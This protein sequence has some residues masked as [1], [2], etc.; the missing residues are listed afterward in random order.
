MSKSS[1]N[2][3]VSAP[4][5]CKFKYW[6]TGMAKV[7]ALYDN[8]FEQQ[9]KTCRTGQ[10]VANL[11]SKLK[12]APILVKMQNME[13]GYR[14]QRLFRMRT[15]HQRECVTGITVS[16][17]LTGPGMRE[18]SAQGTFFAN[19]TEVSAYLPGGKIVH[20]SKEHISEYEKN[21]FAR[22]VKQFPMSVAGNL[23]I[24]Y[25]LFLAG[26]SPLKGGNN[27]QP[28]WRN[29]LDEV[30]VLQTPMT[31]RL[32]PGLLANL[33]AFFAM[34][35]EVYGGAALPGG[36]LA[37]RY[38]SIRHLAEGRSTY[39]AGDLFTMMQ[40]EEDL[41]E[42]IALETDGSEVTSIGARVL[43]Y[44]PEGELAD[45]LVFMVEAGGYGAGTCAVLSNKCFRV[46]TL[47]PRHNRMDGAGLLRLSANPRNLEQLVLVFRVF[48]Q[49]IAHDTANKDFC[50]RAALMLRMQ[51]QADQAKTRAQAQAS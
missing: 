45:I 24:F 25:R 14:M 28:I 19:E 8:L 16:F 26:F 9:I 18:P 49:Y 35:D 12:N 31:G 1:P 3:P 51:T 11:I 10:D 50:R 30:R 37:A 23:L 40:F 43:L 38:E 7:F 48:S 42:V 6:I 27:T 34:V 44:S 4:T 39:T 21:G 41:K 47:A 22:E 29:M 33:P 32:D 5:L 2:I 15:D 36:P 46:S 13:R 20:G 17:V